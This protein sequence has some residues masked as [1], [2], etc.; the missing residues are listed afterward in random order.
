MCYKGASNPDIHLL[1]LT[2]KKD[3]RM[4]SI[5]KFAH[6]FG[7]SKC[8]T[9]SQNAKSGIILRCNNGNWVLLMDFESFDRINDFLLMSL[10][11]YSSF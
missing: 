1:T 11:L 3:K 7:V 10:C 5:L 4:I 8:E 6:S 2:D 9:I